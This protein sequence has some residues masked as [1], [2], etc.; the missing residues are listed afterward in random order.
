MARNMIEQNRLC[1]GR[2]FQ[3]IPTEYRASVD[4]SLKR[5]VITEGDEKKIL[6]DAR[7]VNSKHMVLGARGTIVG[8]EKELYLVLSGAYFSKDLLKVKSF[9]LIDVNAGLLTLLLGDN[10]L[11]LRDDVGLEIYENI[12]SQ[13]RGFSIDEISRFIKPFWV[14]DI[15]DELVESDEA[16]AGL[17]AIVLL[18]S[19]LCSLDFD[20]VLVNSLA[21]I[22]RLDEQGEFCPAVFRSVTSQ[23]WEYVFLELYRCLERFYVAPYMGKLNECLKL[24]SE[25]DLYFY[26]DEHL[27]WRPKEDIALENLLLG[28]DGAMIERLC[29][30][31]K[32][33][34]EPE[35]S[36][37]ARLAASIYKTR[38]SI[39]HHRKRVISGG[40]REV[41]WKL[42]VTSLAAIVPK[43]MV[44]HREYLK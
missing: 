12:F 10:L 41:N 21:E 39:A 33:S 43:L 13:S 6:Q 4:L 18:E 3:L 34:K 8:W 17:T 2:F 29:D 42:V 40:D 20:P 9:K 38:N 26:I 16:L 19:G 44:K 37:C 7:V 5:Y 23:H 1:F 32:V 31:C 11:D 28:M 30:C 25:S 36:I 27:S 35:D 22:I 15:K 14:F 24:E